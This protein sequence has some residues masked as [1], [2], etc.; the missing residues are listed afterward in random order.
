MIDFSSSYPDSPQIL[1]ADRLSCQY[2]NTRVCGSGP[3]QT[4]DI[5]TQT[6]SLD[7][8]S[9]QTQQHDERIPL[10]CDLNGDLYQWKLFHDS[11]CSAADLHIYQ[12]FKNTLTKLG[13]AFAIGDIQ[14]GMDNQNRRKKHKICVIHERILNQLTDLK[15]QFLVSKAVNVIILVDVEVE[16]RDA[17]FFGVRQF[18]QN[19]QISADD[20]AVVNPCSF[21]RRPLPE[22]FCRLI[23]LQIFS[24]ITVADFIKQFKEFRVEPKYVKGFEQLPKSKLKQHNSVKQSNYLEQLSHTAEAFRVAEKPLVYLHAVGVSISI[25]SCWY[26]V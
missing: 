22:A 25:A 11:S 15:L 1:L 8:S 6:W 26:Q 5:S 10:L 18:T 12:G 14:G 20:D 21:T 23:R 19:I 13:V 16:R 17:S 7:I 24:N 4:G 2:L 9:I 3:H